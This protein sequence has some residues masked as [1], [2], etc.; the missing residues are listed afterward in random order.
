MQQPSGGVADGW[1][2]GPH[3]EE[4]EEEGGGESRKEEEHTEDLWSSEETQGCFLAA[5]FQLLNSDRRNSGR[6]ALWRWGYT[7]G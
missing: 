3:A 7:V 4:E 2:E 1:W 5:G 6:E